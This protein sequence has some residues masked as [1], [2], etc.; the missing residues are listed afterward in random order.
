MNQSHSLAYEPHHDGVCTKG[1]QCNG[2][3][4]CLQHAR[5]ADE[6]YRYGG[7]TKLLLVQWTL[8]LSKPHW[9]QLIAQVFR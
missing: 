5:G 6:S 9:S 2:E 7:E 8:R 3:L 4:N 1:V